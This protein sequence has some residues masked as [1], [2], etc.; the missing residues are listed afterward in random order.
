MAE[1]ETELDSLDDRGKPAREPHKG[2]RAAPKAVVEPPKVPDEGATVPDEGATPG[3]EDQ[4]P[5]P[6]AAAP[7]VPD[8]DGPE[9]V[10]IVDLRN[11]YRA[12]KKQIKEQF[13]P[14]VSK[15]QARV[16]ELEE[17]S[18][19]S[20]DIAAKLEQ[21]QKR[22]RELEDQ[23]SF[24]DYSKSEEFQEKH[25]KPYNAAYYRAVSDFS[26]LQVREADGTDPESGET[27]F[28]FRQATDKDLIYLANLPLSKMD[29]EA[30]AMF[31]KSAGRVIRHVEKVRDLA[32]A[33]QEALDNAAKN[34]ETRRTE[35]ANTEK[36]NS[37]K[38]KEMFQ[39]EHKRLQEKYPK[40][41]AKDETDPE[42]NQLL[43]KG[44]AMADRIFLR[45]PENTPKSAEEAV[46]LH[47]LAYNKIANH[48]RLARKFKLARERIAELEKSLKEF[49]AS[50]P[51]AG[52]AGEAGRSGRPAD[53]MSEANA[54]LDS[55][56]KL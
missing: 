6:A 45:T 2:T 27:K 42:G 34:A 23:I 8:L 5:P 49:E 56:D 40:F 13:K 15:L 17:G 54:E 52:R 35:K 46:R 1:Y 10:K 11:H 53:P 7:L 50:E 33:Q 28:K 4:T 43:E 20:K 31:G 24:V 51:G 12:L 14:E 47:A 29:D 18:G 39:S 26:Q 19:A 21:I 32:I 41:F 48:D 55:L 44:I 16:K 25:V 30:D 36:L 9:P 38:G 3:D 22:N 37:T